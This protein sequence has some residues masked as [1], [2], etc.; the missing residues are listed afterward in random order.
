[1]PLM[2]TATDAQGWRPHDTLANRLRLVRAE[3]KMSQREAAM[4]S[5]ISAR[6]WQNAEDGR[7]VRDLLAFIAKVSEHLDV[8]RD[9]LTWGGPLDG[10]NPRPEG[11]GGGVDSTDL[12]LKVRSSTN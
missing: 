6:V 3:K 5:G 7:D 10:E 4:A 9:W 8:D 1:M 2:T 11:P 12:G